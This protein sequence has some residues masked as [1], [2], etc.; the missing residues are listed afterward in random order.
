MNASAM[1]SID[2]SQGEGGGQILRTALALSLLT[3]TPFR[4]DKIRAARSRP[5]LLRQHLA[6]VRAAR[7]IG[8]ADAGELELGATELEFRPHRVRAGEYRFDVTSAGS[9]CLVVQT[10]LPPLLL[11][12]GRSVL[13]VEGGTHNPTAPPWEYLARVLFPLLE[14]MGARVRTTLER[15]GFYPAGG[16]RLRVEIEPV[17]RLTPIEL[18]ERGAIVS[19]S[20]RALVAHLPPSI[21]ERELRIVS[22]ELSGFEGHTEVV[23]ATDSAGPG[24]ALLLELV[25]EH[26]TEIFASFGERGLRAE[27]VAERAVQQVREYLLHDAPVG[28]HLADQL[29]LPLAICGEGAFRTGPLTPHAYTNL[30]VVQRFLPVRAE[31][32]PGAGSDVVVR[33]SR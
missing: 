32:R 13:V 30:D 21:G 33:I 18:L 25:S 28:P 29:V 7:E 10:V 22:Q 8:R 2:G 11:A 14:R 9:A 1:L 31:V 12:E 3:G 5:G 4:I 19:R 27:T 24:N 23:N 16:G 15:H 17:A 20:A 26:V 6:A